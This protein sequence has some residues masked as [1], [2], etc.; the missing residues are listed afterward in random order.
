MLLILVVGSGARELLSSW[1][2]GQTFPG[3]QGNPYPKLKKSL[4]FLGY[5]QVHVK[6][7]WTSLKVQSWEEAAPPE[8]ISPHPYPWGD[9][10]SPASQAGVK[11][12]RLCTHHININIKITLLSNCRTLLL[13][14]KKTQIF[15]KLSALRLHHQLGRADEGVT[16]K[17]SQILVSF[18]PTK[19]NVRQ[20]WEKSL[21]FI[22]IFIM[23]LKLALTTIIDF[24][25]LNTY[26]RLTGAR[27]VACSIFDEVRSFGSYRWCSRNMLTRNMLC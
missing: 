15:K 22:F 18:F 19:S 11:H 24:T 6:K 20:L 2:G 27:E 13:V 17:A 23:S 10:G 12:R 4:D 26:S 25:S 1:G 5:T 8:L 16:P 9:P 21:F 7:K 3:V 14:G